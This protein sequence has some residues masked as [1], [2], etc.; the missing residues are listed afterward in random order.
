MISAIAFAVF[1]VAAIGPAQAQV[2]PPQVPMQG[3]PQAYP[4]GYPQGCPARVT[5]SA[6][7]IYGRMMRHFASLGLA[8]QQQQRI[9]S[10]VDAF[11]RMHPAGSPLDPTAMRQLH[12]QVR[13]VLTPQQLAM[14]EQE[15]QG[16]GGGMRRCP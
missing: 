1:S 12:E 4:Q 14:L 16:H 8:P 9:Q 11:S 10:L 7:E 3:G 13:A 6:Q 5:P 2:P 15:H